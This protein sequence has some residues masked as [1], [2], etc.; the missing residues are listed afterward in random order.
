MLPRLTGVLEK[1]SAGDGTWRPRAFELTMNKLTY[2]ERNGKRASISTDRIGCLG[3]AND[4][5]VVYEVGGAYAHYLRESSQSTNQPTLQEWRDAICATQPVDVAW[6]YSA[7]MRSEHG[8]PLR[9]SG[10]LVKKGGSRRSKR[11]NW[12]TRHFELSENNEEEMLLRY[13]DDRRKLKGV[14]KLQPQSFVHAPDQVTL[15][16]RH[17]QKLRDGIEQDPLYFELIDTLDEKGRRRDT[18]SLRANSKREFDEWLVAL[19]T[20]IAHLA[21]PRSPKDQVFPMT[22]TSWKSPSTNAAAPHLI[23]SLEDATRVFALPAP[24]PGAERK[25][26]SA[27]PADVDDQE[28]DDDEYEEALTEDEEEQQRPRVVAPVFSKRG[29]LRKNEDGSP[30]KT[31]LEERNFQEDYQDPLSPPPAAKKKPPPPPPRDTT[32]T[33][34]SDP[35]LS[36]L[37]APNQKKPP[38]P[39]PPRTRKGDDAARCGESTL[40]ASVA[41]RVKNINQRNTPAPRFVIEAPIEFE[42]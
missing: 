31:A 13:Y 28:E 8:S 23:H 40:T 39:P 25:I 41:E 24:P 22:M 4:V 16:G 27:Y 9:V 11:R 10:T 34:Q 7:V 15:R 1:R 5:L 36:P 32:R 12:N 33:S 29:G 26:M 6:P 2:E 37:E 35:S 20:S 30:Q 18:F 21:E 3:L 38:P 19:R 42:D 17:S 14:V